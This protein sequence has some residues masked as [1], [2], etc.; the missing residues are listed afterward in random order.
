MSSTYNFINIPDQKG[1]L[2]TIAELIRITNI[3]IEAI[4]NVYDDHRL[5]RNTSTKMFPLQENLIYRIFA[6]FHQYELLVEGLNNKTI[7]DL[8]K[9]PYDGILESH[10]TIYRYSYELSSIVD[11]IFFHLCSVFDYLGHFISYM[12]EA[13]KDKTLDWKSL[14]NKA[15]AAYKDTLKSADGIR[16][17]DNKI[18][19]NLEWHRSQLIHRRRDSR[20]I[21]I[22]KNQKSNQLS[23]IFAASAETMKHFKNIVA[24]YDKE[25]NYT[26]DCLPSVVIYQTLRS[27]N[28]LLD[29]LRIDLL[30]GSTFE[31]NVK[32]P[33]GNGLPYLLHPLTKKLQPKSEVIWTDYKRQLKK[34]YHNYGQRKN[35]AEA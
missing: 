3:G 17:I 18:R 14:A 8:N 10:P 26:L 35:G 19:I 23:L 13:N 21:G 16:E 33:K 32:N 27:I 25:S 30:S 1:D 31:E 15:R 34:F 4:M 5:D 2:K 22:T 9:E 7:V 6:V 29:L 28:F 11:S 24:G 12:F 20:R